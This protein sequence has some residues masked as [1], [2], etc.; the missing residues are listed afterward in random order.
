VGLDVDDTRAR[1]FQFMD[2]YGWT[3]P[4]IVDPQRKRAKS[5][6]ADWQPFVA[7]IDADGK[8]VASYAG[9][10]EKSIWEALV[11]RLPE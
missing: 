9:G 1:A 8:I 3:W 5:I 10:G 7:V 2:K 11:G 4:S 6:G